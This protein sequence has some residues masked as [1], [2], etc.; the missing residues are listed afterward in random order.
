MPRP[1]PVPDATSKPFW[2]ACNEKRLIV[3]HC[4]YCDRK[5]FPPEPECRECGWHFHLSWLETSGRGTIVGYSVTYE[6]R[7]QAWHP[8]QPFNNVIIAL[9]EDPVI[10]FHSNLP[11]V[12]VDEVPVGATVEVEFLEVTD[13]QLIPEWRVVS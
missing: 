1:I 13:G 7:I 3:Q 10:N 11:G 9:E 5:Q 12:P 8:E 6:S 4:T 2:D